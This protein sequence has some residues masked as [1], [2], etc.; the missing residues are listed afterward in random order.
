MS[1]FLQYARHVDY[2]RPVETLIPGVQGRV[3]GVLARTQ[4][5]MTIRTAA[6]LAGVSPQQA[7]VVI[8]DLVDLGIVNRREAG[9]SSLVRLEREN[10][11]ARVVL[12]LARLHESVMARLAEHA[13]C[14]APVPANILVFGSFGRGEATAASDLD[15]LAVRPTGIAA[16]DDEWV[17]ALAIWETAARRITGNPVHL[18]VVSVD[19]VPALL[20]RRTGPWRAIANEGVILVGRPLQALAS[21]A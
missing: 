14:I 11:A 21:V 16:E 9:S 20:R 1:D 8:A 3:L 5:E 10:E 6:S 2:A 4:A 13:R 7:S 19:E 17:D 12:A 18:V 15:V